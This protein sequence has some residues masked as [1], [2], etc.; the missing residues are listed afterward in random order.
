MRH[1]GRRTVTARTLIVLAACSLF[2][3]GPAGAVTLTFGYGEIGGSSVPTSIRNAFTTIG[4]EYDAIFTDTKIINID[5]E[6][7]DIGAGNLGETNQTFDV[8]DYASWETEL[9]AKSSDGTQATADASLP[10]SA[11][12]GNGFVVLSTA[13]YQILGGAP[14]LSAFT[15]GSDNVEY[16]AEL[17]FSST[18]SFFFGSSGSGYDFNS[19]AEHELD[20]ALGTVS[21]VGQSGGYAAP[22]DFFRY[23]DSSGTRSFSSTPGTPAYF[24]LDG[25]NR[26]VQYNNSGSGDFGD[27]TGTCFVQNYAECPNTVADIANPGEPE[28]TILNAVGYDIAVAPEPGTFALL[29]LG[30]AFAVARRHKRSSRPAAA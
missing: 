26:L 30:A 23:Q 18:A 16:N 2:G 25:H 9:K 17:L 29:G 5:V 21:W 1:L 28:I 7:A 11:P 27:F 8:I 4:M 3:V 14:P 12:V 10:S 24:S 19:V 6:F 13:N 15:K 20:E 22:V